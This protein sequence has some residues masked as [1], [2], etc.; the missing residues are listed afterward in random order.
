MELDAAEGPASADDGVFGLGCSPTDA[1]L[2]LAPV[3]VDATTS[4]RPGTRFGPERILQASV[5]VDLFD[6]EFEKQP[7]QAG[8]SML[9]ADPD[10]SKTNSKARELVDSFR[11]AGYPIDN[12]CEKI[13]AIGEKVNASVY[14]TAKMWLGQDKRVGVVGGDHSVPF[15]SIKAHSERYEGLGVLHIDAHADLRQ[16]YEGFRWSHASIMDNVL[17]ETSIARLV[18]VGI[19]DFAES[20]YARTQ[21]DER[22]TTFFDSDVSEKLFNG[23][24]YAAICESIVNVLPE[25]VYVSFDI[26]GLSPQLC[27]STGTPVPG[28]LSFR[29]AVFLLESVVQSGRQIVGFDLVEVAGEPDGI[30]A[31]VGA[32]ILYKLCCLALSGG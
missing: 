26:D 6:P 12:T 2:V 18:Q 8:I 1:A 24:T 4:Y 29:Q 21:E 25:L 15:G 16:A 22:V 10:L 9:A 31:N 27:P 7:Y 11:Q 3:P 19:R 13:D 20:E 5:Q 28:G 17:R 23:T 14:A 30:D 32:R